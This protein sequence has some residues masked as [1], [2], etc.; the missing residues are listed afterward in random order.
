[1]MTIIYSLSKRK[2]TTFVELLSVVPGGRNELFT[3][4]NSPFIQKPKLFP[5]K[6]LPG[7]SQK[8]RIWKGLVSSTTTCPRNSLTL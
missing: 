6:E 1:M 7:Y 2:A 4:Q 5:N 8:N 3:I